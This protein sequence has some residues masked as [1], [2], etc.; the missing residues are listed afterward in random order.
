MNKKIKLLSGIALIAVM[1]SCSTNK[2]PVNAPTPV[3]S[4]S[5]E[6]SQI[7]TDKNEDLSTATKN[8]V[9]FDFDKYNVD[10]SKYATVV[11]S[12]ANYLAAT[13]NAKVQVQ[14]NTDDIG[15]VEYNLALG[16]RRADAVKKSLI[17]SGAN[18]TQIEA[19]SNGK[20]KPVEDNNSEANRAFNRRADI[21]Y[22]SA[23]PS[24][25]EEYNGVPVNKNL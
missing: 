3:V 11:S 8:S 5:S 16:Q 14:G 21:N 18:A 2:S 1:A 4:A 23:K 24:F 9:F 19:T 25:V 10:S 6:G 15:S 7:G 22:T 13:N 20:L 12:N 17:M